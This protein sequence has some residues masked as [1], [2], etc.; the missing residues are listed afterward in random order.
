MLYSR[1]PVTTRQT[2]STLLHGWI[3]IWMLAVPLFHVHPEADHHH[4]ESG[5]LH[6]GTVHTVWSGDLDCEFGSQKKAAPTGVDLSGHSSPAWHEH[7]ELG[8]SLLSNS[9]DR[10][11]FNPLVT[12]V[13]FSAVAVMPVL[14]G[15]ESANEDLRFGPSST[16]FLHE[17][18]S[19]APPS[20]LV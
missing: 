9:T 15:C 7:P 6:G 2:L 18:P 5:H 4:G 19:R 1:F 10:K 12:P 20:L 13:T 3:I 11:P 8:F 17:L 14:L 16:L